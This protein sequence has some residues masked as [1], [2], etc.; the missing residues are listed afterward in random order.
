M[1]HDNSRSESAR[2]GTSRNDHGRAERPR[3]EKPF[4]T[5]DN[6]AFGDV[7]ARNVAVGLRLHREMLGLLSDMGQDWLVRASAEAQLAL[8]LP[9]RLTAARSVPDAVTAYQEWFG[10]WINRCSEDGQRLLSDGQ[11]IVV[12]G[13]RCFIGERSALSG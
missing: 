6:M 3:G 2:N 13:T 8:R 9:N 7:G 11:K 12:T 1:P 10:E 5:T 4:S